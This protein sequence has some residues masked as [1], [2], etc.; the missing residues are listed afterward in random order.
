[1]KRLLLAAGAVAVLAGCSSGSQAQVPPERMSAADLHDATDDEF[2]RLVREAGLDDY[3]T[4]DQAIE[5]AEVLCDGLDNGATFFDAHDALVSETPLNTAQAG[6]ITGLAVGTY[7]PE[8]L[9][10]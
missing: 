10:D 8:V 3:L 7:C 5:V 2:W 1:M 9:E 4:R 6:R